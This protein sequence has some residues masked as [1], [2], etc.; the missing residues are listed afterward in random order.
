M[1][2]FSVGMNLLHEVKGD[3]AEAPSPGALQ[4]ILS[5][6]ISYIHSADK[7]KSPFSYVNTSKSHFLVKSYSLN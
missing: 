4:E 6:R 3:D 7:C 5:I 1:Y 2:P